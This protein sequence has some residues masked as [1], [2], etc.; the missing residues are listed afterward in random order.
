MSCRDPSC[1]RRTRGLTMFANRRGGAAGAIIAG[2]AL[3]CAAAW[4]DDAVSYHGLIEP[5][6][7]ES[8][9]VIVD[10]AGWR[11]LWRRVD[12]TP[13]PFAPGR[14]QA[15]AIIASSRPGN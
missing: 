10:E 5:A 14:Q 9:T 8:T 7:D 6:L 4:S 1:H 15:L 11:E 12:D 2:L 13:P 3:L